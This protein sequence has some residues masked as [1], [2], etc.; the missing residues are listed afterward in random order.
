MNSVVDSRVFER[1]SDSGS[2]SAAAFVG[3]DCETS[4]PDVDTHRM[5]QI[6]VC[7]SGDQLFSARIGWQDARYD[8]DSLCAIGI[9][10]S[11]LHIGE[12]AATVDQALCAW[13]EQF[14][15]AAKSL[16]S[17]GWGVSWFDLPFVTRTLPTFAGTFLCHRSVELNALCYTLD[18]SKTYNDQH[19]SFE[20]WRTMAKR[21]AEYHALAAYGRAAQW[22]DAGYDALTSWLSW[23]WL[24]QIIAD[25]FPASST[26]P[27]YYYA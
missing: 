23:R 1:R 25:P 12:P 9:A 8:L 22:H 14:G 13:L 5:I 17:V 3:L 2:S 7:I 16:V 15:I 26:H 6:G 19:R 10:P 21:V 11:E 27:S 4:G 18:G 20:E 24:R